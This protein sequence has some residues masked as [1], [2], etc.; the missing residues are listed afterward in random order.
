MITTPDI[1]WGEHSKKILRLLLKLGYHHLKVDA[2]IVDENL[3]F[4]PNPVIKNL[5]AVLTIGAN[6]IKPYWQ[7][8]MTLCYGQLALWLIGKD[9]AYR[10]EFFWTLNEILKKSDE[11]QTLIKPYVKPPEQWTPN[12]WQDSK[13]K[14]KRLREEGKLP[15]NAFSFEESIWVKDIQDKRHKKNIKR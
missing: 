9:T 5:N 6:Q 13:N 3:R 4:Y 15:D 11:L 1:A 12:L 10:D 14:T 8:K 7:R 2:D